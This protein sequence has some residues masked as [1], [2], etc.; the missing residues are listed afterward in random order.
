MAR[1]RGK[2]GDASLFRHVSSVVLRRV[3][4]VDA[5]VC[6]LFLLCTDL[7][8]LLYLFFKSVSTLS[9]EHHI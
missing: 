4:A 7:T 1:S 2:H 5:R 3:P 8:F 6:F 9:V